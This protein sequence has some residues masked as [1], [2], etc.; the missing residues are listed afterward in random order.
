[1]PGSTN[2]RA[3]RAFTLIELL[4]V[5]AIISLLIGL[6]LPAVQKVREAANRIKC[7]NNLKQLGLAVNNH[8][9]T[10]NEQLPTTGYGK[11]AD[12]I[13]AG[14][15]YA[16]SYDLG[17]GAF[18]PH[19]PR[20]QLGGW[21]FQLLSFVEQDNLWK[22]TEAYNNVGPTPAGMGQAQA[23]ALGFPMRFFQCPTRGSTRVF[24]VS[25]GNMANNAGYTLSQVPVAQSDYAA[26]GGMGY[27][28]LNG[29]FS[30][31]Y[32][33]TDPNATRPKLKKL[34]DYSDGVSNVIMIGEKLINKSFLNQSQTDDWCG[35]ACGYHSS[36]VRFAALYGTTTP[37]APQ[38]DYSNGGGGNGQGL[39][40]SSHTGVCLFAFGDGAV[41][42]VRTSIDPKVFAQLCLINDGAAISDA[43]YE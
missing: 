31:E 19:G 23:N 12:F 7:T 37:T 41:H 8:V 9:S 20:N 32:Q 28:D 10:F 16:P 39:F 5:I 2:L 1:M 22:G 14:A 6:T 25:A 13:T 42:R 26:N 40:G 27:G 3:R 24:N 43:D 33:V 15:F 30:P 38:S 17:L 4:V 36:N 35:Y 21:G 18:A 34:A 29:A 11:Q